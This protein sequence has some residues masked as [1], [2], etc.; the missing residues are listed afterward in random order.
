[1]I[2]VEKYVQVGVDGYGGPIWDDADDPS[3]AP[4]LSETDGDPQFLYEV[5][6]T[7][8]VPLSDILLFDDN[9]T[10]G[11]GGE[12]DD[13]NPV[14]VSGDDG[15]GVLEFGET[16]IYTWTG[17]WEAGLQTNIATATGTFT[18]DSGNAVTVEDI[19]VANYF[20]LAAPGV[21]TPGFW[22]QEKWQ[23][24]WDGDAANDPSQAGQPGFTESDIVLSSGTPTGLLIG[25]FDL[26]GVTGAD[27][28]TIFLSLDHA[29][30]ILDASQKTLHDTQYVL[31]RDMV[32]TWLNF[33]A[34]NPIED[35]DAS[36][37]DPRDYIDDAIAWLKFTTGG[38]GN[39]MDPSAVP[40]SSTE[41]NTGIDL[42]GDGTIDIPAG[43]L[44]HAAL[45][46]YNNTGM[47][48]GVTY[49]SDADSIL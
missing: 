11:Y 13:F 43:S 44:I 46:E 19:D 4:L 1:M 6:N 40:A 26:D 31:G 7:S 8:D 45:D 29:R 48:N 30:T 12:L 16:W 41:W 28:D 34:G 21:R 33:L 47:I 2:D 27:E 39:P 15:D 22:S 23:A 25:D 18:D 42:G 49:A 36:T 24:F 32:A 35:G 37:T 5:T 17:T 20:G 3:S 14:Y 9:G 38:S 10:S